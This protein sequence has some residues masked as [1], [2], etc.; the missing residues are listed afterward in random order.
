MTTTMAPFDRQTHRE[1][2]VVETRRD[3][4]T[5][6]ACIVPGGSEGGRVAPLREKPDD[7]KA[8]ADL[9]HEQVALD[10]LTD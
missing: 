3:M 2:T 4:D 1:S 7:R 8:E 5:G 9:E 10:G 6:R